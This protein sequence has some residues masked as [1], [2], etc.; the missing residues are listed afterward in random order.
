[1]LLIIFVI[2]V[3]TTVFPKVIIRIWIEIYTL[4]LKFGVQR[5]NELKKIII[6]FGVILFF[7]SIY[8]FTQ[9]FINVDEVGIFILMIISFCL[10]FFSKYFSQSIIDYLKKVFSLYENQGVKIILFTRILGILSIFIII[11]LKFLN[12]QN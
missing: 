9:K 11:Y 5:H 4:L 8:L 7:I 6:L 12:H 10:M 3:L 2:A 1:M